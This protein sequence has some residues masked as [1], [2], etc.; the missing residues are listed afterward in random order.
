MAGAVYFGVGTVVCTILNF[1][2]PVVSPIASILFT[3][4]SSH[5]PP[6]AVITSVAVQPLGILLDPTF[7]S[8]GLVSLI[9]V[10]GCA[11]G[12]NQINGP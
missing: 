8:A 7:G 12:A 11:Y 2:A 3:L 5:A 1:T 9:S 6:A 4:L 10:F